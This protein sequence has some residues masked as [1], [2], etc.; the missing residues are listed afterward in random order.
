MVK[1]RKDLDVN[2]VL[3]LLFEEN[4][5]RKAIAR[6]MDTTYEVIR[7]IAEA[8]TRRLTRGEPLYL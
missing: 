4:L 8:A 7:S 1:Y 2:E 3:R 5:P 6:R